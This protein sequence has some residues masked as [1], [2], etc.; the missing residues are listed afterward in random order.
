MHACK[1]FLGRCT[2]MPFSQTRRGP[3]IE[4]ANKEFS[5]GMKEIPLTNCR[6]PNHVSMAFRGG[7]ATT[8]LENTEPQKCNGQYLVE[9][10]YQL[11]RIECWWYNR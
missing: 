8:H 3:T 7:N 5:S 6:G 9:Y 10:Q 1:V 4:Y 11:Q 2:S